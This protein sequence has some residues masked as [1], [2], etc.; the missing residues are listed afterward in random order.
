LKQPNADPEAVN[1]AAAA[2]KQIHE[3]AIS[4]QENTER[5]FVSLLNP[6]QRQTVRGLRSKD[7]MALALHRLGLLTPQRSNEEVILQ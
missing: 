1:K 4:E 6:E 2:F 3:R 7:S 5:E